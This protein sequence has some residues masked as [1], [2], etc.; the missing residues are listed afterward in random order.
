MD[1]KNFTIGI[2]STTAVILFVGLIIISTQPEPAYASGMGDRGG[3]YIM[4]TG[5]MWEQEELLYVINTADEKMITYRYDMMANQIVP[6]ATQNLKRFFQ[7][8][9][10][11]SR[12]KKGRGSR[13]GGR[14]P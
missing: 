4:L 10:N 2:L 3:D 14:R 11:N 6:T 13:R 1:S 8:P 5:S 7:P 9:P 12:T